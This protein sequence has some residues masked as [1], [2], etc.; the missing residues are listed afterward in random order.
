MNGLSTPIVGISWVP[1]TS[2]VAVARRIIA[3]VE[4]RRVLFSSYTNEVPDQW[5]RS[6][7]EIRDFLTEVVG[8][9][10]I[11]DELMIPVR[12]MRAYCLKFL[13]NTGISERDVPPGVTSPSPR[14][15]LAHA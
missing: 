2:D 1:P 11:G 5:A 13:E 14:T 15:T 6:V 4:V 9:G 8:A 10:G 3:F 7:I 12:R